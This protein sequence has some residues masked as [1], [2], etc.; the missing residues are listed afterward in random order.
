MAMIMQMVMN[1][2]LDPETALETLQF[3]FPQV[4]KRMENAK[5]LRAKG[6]FVPTP[7]A[8]NLGP[9][10][11][12][13]PTGGA[14]KPA[15]G[16]QSKPGGKGGAKTGGKP[17]GSPGAKNNNNRA[18][19]ST[20]KTAKARLAIADGNPCIVVDAESMD[21][22]QIT[23]IAERFELP[24]TAVFC[25]AAYEEKFGAIS[26]EPRYKELSSVEM[27]MA[28]RSA[29]QLAGKVEYATTEMV[30]Q[31]RAT[32]DAKN[33]KPPK[34]GPLPI[35]AQMKVTDT[36]NASVFTPFVAELLGRS[37]PSSFAENLKQVRIELES[38]KEMS[39]ALG[40]DLDS[41]AW[42]ITAY[43]CKKSMAAPNVSDNNGP[44]TPRTGG[45]AEIQKNRVVMAPK[46][47]EGDTSQ[48]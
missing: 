18:G 11:Q 9:D 40:V 8:N 4:T 38:M 45:P 5:K 32:G 47:N 21:E 28:L 19:T 30:K 42:A 20:P 13:I 15:G 26:F 37:I 44:A 17:A 48:V 29:Q 24:A 27:A 34:R 12:V 2:L 10:G 43:R 1:G 14:G 39:E 23:H 6:L 25:R 16:K 31:F 35:D 22:D 7:S 33:P 46:N 41:Y 3:N 36:V